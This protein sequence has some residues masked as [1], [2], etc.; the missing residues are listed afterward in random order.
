MDFTGSP[1]IKTLSFQSRGCRFNA[2]S[3]NYDPVCQAWPEKKKKS[4]LVKQHLQNT[5]GKMIFNFK[6]YS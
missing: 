6:F 3:G 4:M 1:V 5:K 2:W